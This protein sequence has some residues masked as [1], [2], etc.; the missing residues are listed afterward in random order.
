MDK[1]DTITVTKKFME[2]LKDI[3]ERY[4]LTETE[5][6]SLEFARELYIKELAQLETDVNYKGR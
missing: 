1:G 6:R 5:I 2:V 3:P 4:A